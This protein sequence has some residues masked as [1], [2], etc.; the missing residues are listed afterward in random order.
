M[1][2]PSLSHRL[3]FLWLRTN[4]RQRTR[5]L[6]FLRSTV[7]IWFCSAIILATTHESDETPFFA[8]HSIFILAVFASLVALCRGGTRKCVIDSLLGMTAASRYRA[9]VPNNSTCAK[10]DVPRIESEICAATGMF[11]EV[12]ERRLVGGIELSGDR[13]TF[14]KLKPARVLIQPARVSL[15]QVDTD[16]IGVFQTFVAQ[17]SWS[18]MR[19]GVLYGT[20]DAS[21]ARASVPSGSNVTTTSP[22]PT[23]SV[24]V[25]V[26]SIYEPE[27]LA[28]D[29]RVVD[30]GGS[31][32]PRLPKVDALAGLLGLRR[33]GL[34]VT[35]PVRDSAEVVLTGQE[36]MMIAREQSIW[37]GHC[38]LLTAGSDA[39]T[40]QPHFK[41]WQV[42]ERALYLFRLGMLSAHPENRST[43]S[44]SQPLQLAQDDVDDK[45][46]HSVLVLPATSFVDC[47]YLLGGI[48]VKQWTSPWLRNEFIRIS[49]PGERPPDFAD[50]HIFFQQPERQGLQLLQQL[51]DFHVL[52]FLME[53]LY[54]QTD[55]MWV[56][57]VTGVMR[58]SKD[59]DRSGRLCH[60]EAILQERLSQA[61][62]STHGRS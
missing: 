60:L 52:V 27:Q 17:T 42:S 38:L 15:V 36:L 28:N 41:A 46:T 18:V 31:R 54:V 29:S 35:H 39:V 55:D 49:R 32:D 4:P 25:S 5:R 9:S 20:V 11:H 12:K 37:G 13:R 6:L 53:N 30:W 44:S 57:I 47:M 24:I 26:H 56:L 61:G 59:G 14:T 58:R 1:L 43:I 62:R 23:G 7:I 2:P 48:T 33:V 21:A 22:A 50:L 16:S 51:R 3:L 19:I 40:G 10:C 34:I 8:I 45:G